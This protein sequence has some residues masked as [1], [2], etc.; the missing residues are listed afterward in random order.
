MHVNSSIRLPQDFGCSQRKMGTRTTYDCLNHIIGCFVKLAI[1]RLIRATSKFLYYLENP[2]T[3]IHALCKDM[4]K[5]TRFLQRGPNRAAIIIEFQR[6]GCLHCPRGM[7]ANFG[8]ITRR[9]FLLL[10]A[11]ASPAVVCADAK[12]IEPHW[13]K[14]RSIKLAEEKPSH[15][16]VHITDIHHKGDRPYLESVVRKINA[17]SPDAVCFTGD[18][19]EQKQFVAEVLRGLEGIKSPLYGVPGNHDYWS[20]AVFGDI[21]KSFARTGGAWLMDSQV[22]TADGKI[23][24]A[25][26]TCLR[27]APAPLVPKAGAKNILLL[28]YPLLAERVR[29]K[30]DLMLAG[31]SHGG[32]VRIPFYG[33]LVLPFWVGRYQ[34]G[35]FRLPAGPLYVNPGIGWLCT[36]IRFNCRPEIT[37]FEI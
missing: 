26:A 13:V 14:V 8:N 17:L 16:I 22:M 11:L 23:Q 33:A 7:N 10:A 12:W 18:L 21:R 20:D 34:V 1:S 27:G 4:V 24:I 19:I 25:G 28:H 32:Q 31:H 37:V 36:P 29:N 5:H 15:R 3:E 6:S 2:L 35:M 9:Q 30:F